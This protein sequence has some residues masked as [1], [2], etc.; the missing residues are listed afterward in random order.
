MTRTFRGNY[1]CVRRCCGWGVV[2]GR[3]RVAFPRS[4]FHSRLVQLLKSILPVGVVLLLCGAALAD[5]KSAAP[6]G[7][8]ASAAERLAALF[9]DDVI[10]RGRGV[11]V[12]RSQ[13]D[14]AYLSFKA[15][16]AARQQTVPESE[17]LM[18]EAQL[19]DRLITT[20]LLVNRVTDADRKLA[21]ELAE[22]FMA[23]AR[24]MAP[25]EEAFNRQLKAMSITPEQFNQRVMEQAIAEAVLEREIKSTLTV[26][27]ADVD[28]FYQT[29]ADV[30]VRALQADL[31]KLSKDAASSVKQVAGLKE[32]IDAVRQANLARFEQ[33]EKLRV[34]HLLLA[35]RAKDSDEELPDE[36]KRTK[37]QTAEK[38]RARAL[39]GEDFAKLVQEFSED[40]GLKETKG[41]Y[42]FSA[43]DNFVPEFKAAAFSLEV[44]RVSD[45]VTTVFGYHLIKV[46]ERIPKKK[47]PKDD[48]LTKDL[49]DFLLAQEMQKRMP[50][51]FEKLKQ[52]AGIEILDAKYRI[53][54]P[55]TNDPR[56]PSGG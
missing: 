8:P 30:L 48:K 11:E 33:P 9:D 44:G 21:R 23:D 31:E 40:R 47:S 32:Q 17:R 27:D 38:L 24:K 15:N 16:L 18:R 54:V 6:P 52:E 45:I 3:F 26:A 1:R 7:K 10:V 49:R 19:L 39:G 50:A 13:L 46:L 25:N 53:E 14:N 28:E 35:T 34:I 2:F 12:R 43:A 36:Q 42:T 22:K 4:N 5:E 55:R 41:E 20:Q 29:G 56:K 51:F 37:R